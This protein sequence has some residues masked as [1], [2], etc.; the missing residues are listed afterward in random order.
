MKEL[1]SINQL[2]NFY[3]NIFTRIQHWHWLIFIVVQQI[4][5]WQYLMMSYNQTLMNQSYGIAF[6]TWSGVP[7]GEKKQCSVKRHS[8]PITCKNCCLCILLWMPF[9]CI[10]STRNCWDENRW[11]AVRVPS[12]IIAE[13]MIGYIATVHCSKSYSSCESQLNFLSFESRFGVQCQSNSALS[14]LC[15]K[16]NGQ[17]SREYCS[18]QRL[19][20]TWQFETTEWSN[21]ECMCTN[22]VIQHW[23]ANTS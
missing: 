21:P 13:K 20:L 2:L 10:W 17:T 8:T 18:R 3:V 23:F 15:R 5:V 4:L 9:E 14:C 22:L 6:Q 12:N 1:I 7:L 16:S 11:F 19:W